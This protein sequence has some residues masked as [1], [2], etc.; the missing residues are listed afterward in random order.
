MANQICCISSIFPLGFPVTKESSEQV[1]SGLGKNWWKQL[2]DGKYHHFG[3]EVFDKGLH[4]HGAEPGFYNSALKAFEFGKR[5]LN[6][7]LSV[8]FYRDLHKEACAHFQGKKNTT[9][10]KARDAGRFRSVQESG[11]RCTF[12]LDA[13]LKFVDGNNDRERIIGDYCIL[14]NHYGDQIVEICTHGTTLKNKEV[15][16]REFTITPADAQE[17]E[18][19]IQKKFHALKEALNEW[20]NDPVVK[21]AIPGIAL[22]DDKLCI[23][24]KE[25]RWHDFSFDVV[26]PHLFEAFNRTLSEINEELINTPLNEQGKIDSL[27][28]RKLVLIDNLYQ[29]LEWLHP[30][31]DGQ[32]RT[33]LLLLAKLLCENGFT[34]AILDEPY[35]SSFSSREDWL[36][37]LKE[38]MLKWGEERNKAMAAV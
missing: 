35:M 28:E 5:H 11:V 17:F 24:Y 32:G 27:V 25:P 38:G 2:Y 16:G 22:R 1:Y 3:P 12:Y 14:R 18:N 13:M 23:N 34:P 8:E 30:Y 37:Y 10:M 15:W 36:A 31:P 7:K 26:I 21:N 6:E 20:A 33:D 29:N 4:G 19:L 9:E